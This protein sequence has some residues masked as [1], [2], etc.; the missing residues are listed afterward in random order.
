MEQIRFKVQDDTFVFSEQDAKE[1]ETLLLDKLPE[2]DHYLGHE[3]S[4]TK[5][6]VDKSGDDKYGH[7]VIT[8]PTFHG[9]FDFL[10]EIVTIIHEEFLDENYRI[11]QKRDEDI[12]LE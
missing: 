6:L 5:V 8:T 2:L 7:F 11:S 3:I 12:N 10:H 1:L 4:N 9:S